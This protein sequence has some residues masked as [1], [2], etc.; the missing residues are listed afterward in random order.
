MFYADGLRK[1]LQIQTQ[2]QT[3]ASE[4]SCS[5]DHGHAFGILGLADETKPR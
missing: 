2:A 5:W 3:P 4:K 1:N